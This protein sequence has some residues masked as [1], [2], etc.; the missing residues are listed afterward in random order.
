MDSM[1]MSINRVISNFDGSSKKQKSGIVQREVS[2]YVAE[3]IKK[4][5]AAYENMS[6]A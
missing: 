6:M 3:V 2:L 1:Q 5:K 4:S